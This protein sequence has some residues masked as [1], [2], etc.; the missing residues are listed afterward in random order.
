MMR[1]KFSTTKKLLWDHKVRHTLVH[2]ATLKFTWKGKKQSF[3]DHM[4]AE[5]YIKDHIQTQRGD[6]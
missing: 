6:E 1:K 3:T 5:S 2:P 4:E